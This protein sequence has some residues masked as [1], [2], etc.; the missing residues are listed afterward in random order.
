[1][2]RYATELA[3]AVDP[4][5]AEDVSLQYGFLLHDI[6][7]IAIP[8]DVLGKPGPLT[9]EERR[10]MQTHTVLGAQMLGGVAFLRGSPGGLGGFYVELEDGE[11]YLDAHLGPELVAE[12]AMPAGTAFVRAGAMEARLELEAG[13]RVGFGDLAFVPRASERR[14][15]LERAIMRLTGLDLKMEQY[16]AGERFA[17]AVIAA[18]GRAFLNQVWTGPETL[19]TLD[20]IRAPETWIARMEG[21]AS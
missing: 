14:G 15:A 13:R 11:R 4:G 9:D 16:A 20:K 17:D 10:L 19:P 3:R 5:L 6:G 18:R 12:I 8:D 21:P 1:M 7:K 2:Q